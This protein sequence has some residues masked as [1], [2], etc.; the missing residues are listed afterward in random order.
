MIIFYIFLL[1]SNVFLEEAKAG[2]L[3][4]LET[5][6][7]E[8]EF[9]LDKHLKKNVG[10]LLPKSFQKTYKNLYT[11]L[12]KKDYSKS[13]QDW[14]S[15]FQKTSFSRSSTGE[16]LYAFLLFKNGFQVLGLKY[17]LD[18]TD[19]KKINP[20]VYK[21]WKTNTSFDQDVWNY[22]MNPWSQEWTKFFDEE[23]AFKVGSKKEIFINKD[24]NHIEYF[25]G[26]PVSKNNDKSY[27]EWSLVLRL[28]KTG[29]IDSATKILTWLLKQSRDL[30]QKNTIYLT[31]A[32]L[33]YEAGEADAS[34]HYYDKVKGLSFKWLLAQEEKSWIYYSRGDYA[35]SFSQISSFTYPPLQNVLTPSMLLT[36]SLSQLKNCDYTNLT[37]SLSYFKKHFSQ[38]H[39]YLKN[40]L[41]KNSFEIIKKDLLIS[42][43]SSDTLLTSKH[44]PYQLKN[45]NSIKNL[46]LFK[47]FILNND[48][49]LAEKSK[50][51]KIKYDRIVKNLDRKI[52]NKLNIL[53]QKEISQIDKTLK[54]MYFIEIEALYRIH[55]Y[56]RNRKNLLSSGL[57]G[58]IFNPKDKAYIV[59]FPFD[60]KEVWADEIGDYHTSFSKVCPKGSYAL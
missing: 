47:K 36:L 37:S 19:P 43:S 8:V 20:I 24:Q 3:D 28:I 41:K 29:D 49:P 35:R 16:A 48:L 21:L 13:L 42:Y 10:S 30:D 31:I 50:S 1:F 39:V 27:L 52:D 26:L 7:K 59:T 17:L 18:K 4:L 12:E 55:G 56:H 5:N 60:S 14:S 22:F 38:R 15:S 2:V 23:I 58:N 32:R 9:T 45:N 51:I 54:Q 34:L 33:L 57:E 40:L 53:F 11:A 46:I 6:P 25:L 44:L